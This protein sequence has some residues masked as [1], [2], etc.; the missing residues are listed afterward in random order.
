MVTGFDSR[1][2][3]PPDGL[4]LLVETDRGALVEHLARAPEDNIYLLSRVA[5]DGVLNE[6]SASHGRFYGHFTDEI[7]DGVI[8]FGHRKGVVLTGPAEEEFVRAA[9]R[10]ALG[11]ESDW[12]ILVGPRR[13][14]EAF[15]SHYRWRGR[16]THL[17]R[18]QDFHV[19]RPDT[20]TDLQADIRPAE[21]ADLDAVVEMSEQM[22]QEDFRLPPGSLSRAGIR[23]SMKQKVVDGR[24]WVLEEDGE[25]VFKVDVSAQYA[26]G[27]QIE[28]VFT[29]PH[30]RGCGLARAGVAAVSRELLGTSE[31]VSLHV[32]RDN[33]AA[34]RAYEAAGFRKHSEFRLVLLEFPGR[35]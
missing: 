9:A 32:D 3:A 17:N 24:T 5:L 12:V 28:G 23:E 14:A 29:L 19:L 30:R 2:S 18:I 11:A 27:A 7:L 26:G 35:G 34:C 10:L 22:L 13:P 25:V 1:Q 6:E 21:V 15:L 4:R 33:V 20:L 31:F 16:S 8:F